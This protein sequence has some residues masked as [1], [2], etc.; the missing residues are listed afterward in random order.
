MRTCTISLAM[1]LL[2]ALTAYARDEEKRT[3]TY[4]N[5]TPGATPQGFSPAVGDWS[6][7]STD[8]GKVLAQTASKPGFQ[9]R[10]HR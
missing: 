10:A 6:V 2:V 1:T 4:E 8:E 3:W 9:R 7:V 5:D